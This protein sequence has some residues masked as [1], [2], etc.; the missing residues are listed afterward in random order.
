MT[1]TFLFYVFCIVTLH[2]YD[3]V[4]LFKNCEI[5][6]NTSAA[7]GYRAD[8]WI[9][10]AVAV[11]DHNRYPITFGTDLYKTA[12]YLSITIVQVN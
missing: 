3:C 9:A 6:L 1:A 11:S 12:R 4:I 8:S 5:L 10:I 2:K 7:N